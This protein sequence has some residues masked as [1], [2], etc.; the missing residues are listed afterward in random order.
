MLVSIYCLR[1]S[2]AQF[3]WVLV[4]FNGLIPEK[5]KEKETNLIKDIIER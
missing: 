4:A 5:R 3:A 1:K 2:E